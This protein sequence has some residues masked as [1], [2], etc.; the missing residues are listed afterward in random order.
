M[1]ITIIIIVCLVL[2]IF[3]TGTLNINGYE[4]HVNWFTLVALILFLVKIF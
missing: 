2:G 4:I 1:T 3:E